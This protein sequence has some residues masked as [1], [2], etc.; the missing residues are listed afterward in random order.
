MTATGWIATAA[1]AGVMALSGSAAALDNW[2]ER[3]VRVII[4]FAPGGGADVLARTVTAPLSEIFGQ[5]FVPE[6]VTG[7][8]GII[9]VTT[10]ANAEPDNHTIGVLV[11]STTVIAP[12]TNPN[13]T[14]DPMGDFEYIA[15]L[16][17]A[18][19]VFAVNPDTGITTLDELMDAIR[20]SERPFAYGTPGLATMNNLVPAVVFSQAGVEVEH[21]SYQG[22][23]QAV[24]D[25]VAGHIPLTS[26]TLST[27]RTAI[28]SGQ[29]RPIA[30]STAERHP[31]FPDLPTFAELGYPDATALTWFGMGAPAGTD[32]AVVARLN[33]EINAILDRPE[34][35][36]VLANLGFEVM[37]M[38]P[39]GFRQYQEDQMRI[40]GP[41]AQR[42]VVE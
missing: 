11:V 22:A 2:P 21:I 9:G 27:G 34:T 32:P 28:D 41:V 7:A 3:P 25:T 14:Y 10:L 19:V 39:E 37:L 29:L 30:I 23:A 13:I 6:N 35:R 17:G 12:P 33:A 36:A 42:V 26:V 40:F 1:A 31:D 18:P 4:P 38:S 24:S 5:R 16:G 8:G 15:F 20:A